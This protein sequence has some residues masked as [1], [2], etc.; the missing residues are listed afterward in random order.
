MTS[1]VAQLRAQIEAEH[2]AMVW[3]LSGLSSGSAQHAFIE[4]RM[5]HLEISAQR[6]DTLIG[7]EK[8]TDVLCAVFDTTPEREERR[9]A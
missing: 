5:H 3:A 1:E 8:T 2:Q 7:E 6:L 4:R 9:G